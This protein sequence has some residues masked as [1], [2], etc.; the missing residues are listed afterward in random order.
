MVS[1]RGERPARPLT[2]TLTSAFEPFHP[3]VPLWEWSTRKEARMKI[4]RMSRWVLV[5]LAG[6]EAAVLA[7][8]ILKTLG[9]I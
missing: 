6:I 7:L 3:D 2:G 4:D 1:P 9:R 8:F 5:G